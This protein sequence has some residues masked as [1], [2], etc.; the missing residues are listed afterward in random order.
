MKAYA[1]NPV[2]AHYGLRD[3]V[4]QRLTAVV[5]AIYTLVV[6]VCLLWQAPAGHAGW[7]D[8]FTGPFTRLATMLFLVSLL[9]HAWVGMRDVLMDY[10]KGTALRLALQSM[11]GV[12]LVF[13]VIW[14][15]SILWGG[16]QA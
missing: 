15:A 11:V 7:H 3:W 16:G 4:L 14:S 13:Y 5:M 1:K 2:G 12:V 10:V 8:F 6:A 9:Y